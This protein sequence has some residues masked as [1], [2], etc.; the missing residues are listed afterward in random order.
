[1]AEPFF[2]DIKRKCMAV[3]RAESLKAFEQQNR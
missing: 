1:M 2:A 3:I